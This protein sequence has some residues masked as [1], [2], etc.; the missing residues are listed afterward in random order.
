M[1]EPHEELAGW[2]RGDLSMRKTATGSQ[3]SQRCDQL[4]DQVL[5]CSIVIAPSAFYDTVEALQ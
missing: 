3:F 4:N 2:Q 1:V 5:G